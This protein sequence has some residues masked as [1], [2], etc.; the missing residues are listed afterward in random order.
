MEIEDTSGLVEFEQSYY[1]NS[2]TNCI[3]IVCQNEC[4]F[5]NSCGKSNMASPACVTDTCVTCVMK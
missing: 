5:N 4:A 1:R 2:R 3:I